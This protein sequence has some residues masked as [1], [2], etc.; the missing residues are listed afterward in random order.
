MPVFACAVT[1]T[2]TVWTVAELFVLEFDIPPH[3]ITL[4]PTMSIATA[5]NETDAKRRKALRRFEDSTSKSGRN[6]SVNGTREVRDPRES[7][8]KDAV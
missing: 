6:A 1:V 2:L 4:L 3:P 5:S 7:D 8:L